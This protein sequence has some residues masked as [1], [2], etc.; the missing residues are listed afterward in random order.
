MIL[1][2]EYW[3]E[4]QDLQNVSNIIREYYNRDL[5]DE[6]DRLIPVHSDDEYD[7]LAS[8]LYDKENEIISIKNEIEVLEN[9]V[10]S[11]KEKIKKLEIK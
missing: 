7:D 11:L 4:V 2:G 6:I 5:A 9:D 3:E 10:E 8:E 1:I